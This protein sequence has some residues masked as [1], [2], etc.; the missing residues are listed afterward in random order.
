MGRVRCWDSY[1][2]RWCQFRLCSLG[3]GRCF[4][5]SSKFLQRL[6]SVERDGAGG[7]GGLE[8]V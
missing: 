6:E 2:Q 1:V 3:M 5:A 7:G 4:R 8:L